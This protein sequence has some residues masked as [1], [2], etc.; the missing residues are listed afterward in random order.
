MNLYTYCHNNPIKYDDPSGHRVA[1]QDYSDVAINVKSKTSTTS[2]KTSSSKTSNSSSKT[3]TSKTTAK[4]TTTVTQKPTPVP[5]VAP[6]KSTTKAGS[7][8]DSKAD[9]GNQDNTSTR[10]IKAENKLN[11]ILKTAQQVTAYIGGSFI[12][13]VDSAIDFAEMVSDLDNINNSTNF[14][15]GAQGVL[16]LIIDTTAFVIPVVDGPINS[17]GKVYDVTRPGLNAVDA[18][19]G[20]RKTIS[21]TDYENIYQSSIHNAGKDKVM[22]GKYDGGGTTSY[23]NKAGKDYEYFSLGDDWNKIRKQYGYTEDDMFK[24]FNESFLDDG[25]NA[26]KTFKFSH[27]PVKDTGSLGKEYQYL[28]DNNYKWDAGTMTMYPRK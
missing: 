23:I 19:N 17:I 16:N 7:G 2:N 13:G 10:D 8:K 11:D 28:L 27:N 12:P 1:V 25:I 22:L 15:E 3:G 24:L 5:T 21:Y 4:T 26:G 9:T 14:F 18:A 6:K 20:A